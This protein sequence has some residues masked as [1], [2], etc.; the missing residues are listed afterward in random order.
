MIGPGN[1]RNPGHLYV[2]VE[3]VREVD[4][5]ELERFVQE[6]YGL[7]S[8]YVSMIAD[9]EW[10]N[11]SQYEISLGEGS[12]YWDT[13]EDSCQADDLERCKDLLKGKPVDRV[14]HIGFLL[15]YAA[16]LGV[17]HPGTYTV[18]VMW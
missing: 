11:D 16:L 10:N 2:K 13:D 15:D 9:F 4:Y 6:M 14:P 1:P 17:I 18:E 12:Y 8:K 7:D 5:I 3:T